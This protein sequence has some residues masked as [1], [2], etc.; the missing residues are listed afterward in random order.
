MYFLAGAAQRMW[1]LQKLRKLMAANFGDAINVNALLSSP[2]IDTS[3]P[4]DTR[5]FSMVRFLWTLY[6]LVSSADNFCKQ[7]GPRS[8]PRKRLAWSGSNLFDTLMVFLEEFFEKVDFENN[9]QTTK[10]HENLRRGQRV[11]ANL[12]IYLFSFTQPYQIGM[13]KLSRVFPAFKD[14]VKFQIL[15]SQQIEFV[16]SCLFCLIGWYQLLMK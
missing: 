1:A 7:F 2:S 9:Q 14:F 15:F 11:K 12:K 6:L 5:P 8:G 16:K 3:E 13:V 4:E 10:K